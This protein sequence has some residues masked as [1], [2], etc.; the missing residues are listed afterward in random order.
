M[1]KIAKKV[2]QRRRT[3]GRPKPV[4][5]RQ[6]LDRLTRKL[7]KVLGRV[8]EDLKR[9]HRGGPPAADPPPQAG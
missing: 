2:Q 3:V 7:I 5:W 6:D 4:R 1:A 8:R 9:R